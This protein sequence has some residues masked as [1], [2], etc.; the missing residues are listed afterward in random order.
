[1][2]KRRERAVVRFAG[3]RD[4]GRGHNARPGFFRRRAAPASSIHKPSGTGCGPSIGAINIPLPGLRSR[5]KTD[6]QERN[7]P[8]VSCRWGRQQRG[9]LMRGNVRGIRGTTSLFWSVLSN[10]SSGSAH[11]SSPSCAGGGRVV[12][13]TGG[14]RRASENL[15]R[16]GAHGTCATALRG[17]R[18]KRISAFSQSTT[19]A[20]PANISSQ[21]EP[22]MS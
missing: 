6:C 19:L 5:V 22:S 3:R 13:H 4:D 8:T 9:L 10:L 2:E 12:N 21:P 16:F 1:V 14:L 20:F 15:R 7:A 11:S 17:S 18:S